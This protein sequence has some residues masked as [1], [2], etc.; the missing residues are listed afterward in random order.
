MHNDP[1]TGRWAV[2]PRGNLIVQIDASSLA[3]SVVLTV[4]DIVVKDASSLFKKH[5]FMHINGAELRQL[6]VALIWL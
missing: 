3:L 6:L 1:I 5:D 2:N 4:D